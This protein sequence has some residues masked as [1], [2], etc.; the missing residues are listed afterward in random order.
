MFRNEVHLDTC[1]LLVV[2][3]RS[4]RSLKGSAH[5]SKSGFLALAARRLHPGY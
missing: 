3:E 1:Y 4:K 5:I 2:L